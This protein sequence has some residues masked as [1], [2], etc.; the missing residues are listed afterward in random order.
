[1]FG[2][3]VSLRRAALGLAAL[4]LLSISAE[5]ASAHDFKAGAITID[6]PWSRATPP[7]ASVGG[8]YLTITNDG[9]TPDRLVSATISAADRAEIHEMAVKDGVMTMRPVPDGVAVPAHG[10]VTFS[11]GGYHLMFVKLAKP[12]VKGEK[13][14]GTLTFEKAGTVAVE[15]DVDAIGATPKE[16][17]SGHGGNAMPGMNMSQ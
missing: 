2:S 7:G 9:D 6:H 17:H 14:A 15:F 4:A 16:D 1:M 3:L 13:I 12:L 10:S 11:P 8:G 5:T